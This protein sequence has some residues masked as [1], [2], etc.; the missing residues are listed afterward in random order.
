MP[1]STRELARLTG[2]T[3]NTIRHYHRLGLLDEPERKDNGYKQYGASHL[4][5]LLRVRRL[6]DL[7]VPLGRIARIERGGADLPA[8]LRELDAELAQSIERLQHAR[9][10]ISTVLRVDAPADAPPG[11]A[12]ISSRLSAPDRAVVHL[13]TRLYDDDAVADLRRMVEVDQ[14]AAEVGDEIAALP[15]DADESTRQRLAERLAPA[16][17]R[18]L[19]DYPWLSNPAGRLRSGER[20]TRQL[21]SEAV[22]EL[23]NGA[24]VD[25]IARAGALARESRRSSTDAA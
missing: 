16:V 13:Y 17:A 7:C 11:F 6:V 1:W 20:L 24:Q 14:E 12:A 23:Y 21:L 3:V 10:D 18:N 5:R 25:V 8:A 9:A 4:I 2:T 19:D 15:E 22:S